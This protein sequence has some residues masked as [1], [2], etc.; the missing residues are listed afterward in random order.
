MSVISK[1]GNSLAVRIPKAIASQLQLT[2]GSEISIDVV[3][4]NII[5]KPTHQ[6]KKYTLEEL[7]EGMTPEKQHNEVD[8][9]EP[10]GEEVLA[11]LETLVT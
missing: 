6:R 5:I 4:K 8:W 11:K 10:V 2:E 1:W 3:E 7:L 9:G